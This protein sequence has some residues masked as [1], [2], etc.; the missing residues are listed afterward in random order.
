MKRYI[1]QK[2]SKDKTIEKLIKEIKLIFKECLSLN[3]L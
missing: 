3:T 1:N 2:G